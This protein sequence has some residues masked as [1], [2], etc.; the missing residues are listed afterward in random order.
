MEQKEIIGKISGTTEDISEN[1]NYIKGL[2]DIYNVL[3]LCESRRVFDTPYTENMFFSLFY[4]QH[5][6][7]DRIR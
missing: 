1:I 4:F 3:A 5:L 7:A 2:A 6:I